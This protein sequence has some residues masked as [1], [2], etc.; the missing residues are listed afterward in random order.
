MSL[1]VAP[2][3]ARP[4]ISILL[5]ITTLLVMVFLQ[6]EE[7]RLGYVLLKLNRQHRETLDDKREREILL[8]KYTRPQFVEK[9]A[10]NRLTLR[11]LSTS[12]IIHLSG[13]GL[14]PVAKK[15]RPGSLKTAK[16][17]LI[18]KE[19]QNNRRTID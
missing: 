10:Q 4:L 18:E 19:N 14:N 2:R 15:P 8:A 12:Q 1:S 17:Q 6:M 13:E 7:R 11:K 16:S 9:V 3:A 5:I